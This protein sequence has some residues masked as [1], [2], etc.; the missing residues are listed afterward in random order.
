MLGR[1]STRQGPKL[2]ISSVI[3]NDKDLAEKV[4]QLEHEYDNDLL[5]MG[6][7]EGS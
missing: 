7:E 5:K 2:Q 3:E 1:R 4:H 6:T